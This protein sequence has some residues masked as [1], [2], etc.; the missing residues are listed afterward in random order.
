[1][2]ERIAG[3]I[4]VTVAFIVSAI[5]GFFLLLISYKLLQDGMM[6]DGTMASQLFG[7]GIGIVGVGILA[8]IYGSVGRI[9]WS[10]AELRN[11]QERG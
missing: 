1:M 2:F 10:F 4:L 7:A 6:P 5:F 9:S 3:A 8:K 11:E